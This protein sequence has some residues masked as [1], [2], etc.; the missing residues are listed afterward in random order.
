MAPEMLK[1]L[2]YSGVAVDI[3]SYGVML[4][5]LRTMKEPFEKASRKDEGYNALYKD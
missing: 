5:T 4:L 2:P 3:F 1:G